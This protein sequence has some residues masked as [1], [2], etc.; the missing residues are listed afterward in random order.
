MFQIL[1]ET[2]LTGQEKMQIDNENEERDLRNKEQST[3]SDFLIKTNKLGDLKKKME[4]IV[5]KK[6]RFEMDEKRLALEKQELEKEEKQLERE[7]Y[8]L[9]GDLKWTE[10]QL[11]EIKNDRR[12][13][14]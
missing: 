4:D 10:K 9:E 8:Q 3:K 1:F 2:N 14:S 7:I 11:E 5:M 13:Q 6:R 12:S